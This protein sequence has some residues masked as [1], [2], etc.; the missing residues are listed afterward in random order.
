MTFMYIRTI[1]NPRIDWIIFDAI[2]T[3]PFAII[4][5][6]GAWSFDSIARAHLHE[7]AP[8]YC[9]DNDPKVA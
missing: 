6:T 4:L 7:E 9:D 1:D 5:S 2:L 3:K 8:E